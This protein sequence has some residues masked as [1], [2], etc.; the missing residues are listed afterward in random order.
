[1]RDTSLRWGLGMGVLS[2]AIGTGALLLGAIIE[3][4]K[5]VTTADAVALALFIRGML[6]LIS[7]GLALGLAYYAGLRVAR[8][9]F[10]ALIESADS[11]DTTTNTAI[12]SLFGSS[13]LGTS[14]NRRYAVLAGGLTMFC[15]WLITSMYIFVLPPTD[16]SVAPQGN[17]LNFIE[18]RLLL[19]F[20]YVLFGLGLGGL[21]GRAPAARLLLDRITMPRPPAAPPP[22]PPVSLI[23]APPA[24][25]LLAEPASP[26]P[27][28][29][30]I[31]AAD[32]VFDMSNGTATDVTA[33]PA[34][35]VADMPPS[36]A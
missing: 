30:P 18:T 28:D 10:Q 16:Q 32:T 2:A 27:E 13:V 23:A 15:Y 5:Q 19:G 29:T 17:L 9:Y 34:D 25:P 31:L 22:I 11:L 6:V 26:A 7:L 21:G 33:V 35:S 20:I 12:A 4:F 14:Q 1:M 24:P 36:D 8:A 3:P